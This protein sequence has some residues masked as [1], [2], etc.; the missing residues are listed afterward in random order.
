MAEVM[1]RA[2]RPM[3]TIRSGAVFSLSPAIS[4]AARATVPAATSGCA[5]IRGAPLSAGSSPRAAATATTASG[6]IAR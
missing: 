2:A 4:P 3:G 6:V 1:N 5:M